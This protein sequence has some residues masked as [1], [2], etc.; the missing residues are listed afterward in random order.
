MPRNT[1]LRGSK[2]NNLDDSNIPGSKSD[3]SKLMA[4]GY[5]RRIK[6]ITYMGFLHVYMFISMLDFGGV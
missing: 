4:E 1:V 5:D 2:A 6:D 3:F